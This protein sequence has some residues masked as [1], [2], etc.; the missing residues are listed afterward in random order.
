[1]NAEQ[2][3]DELQSPQ[4][5][6]I[7]V[8][9]TQ[10]ARFTLAIDRLELRQAVKKDTTHYKGCTLP[11]GSLPGMELTFEANDPQGGATVSTQ[12]PTSNWFLR[13]DTKAATNVLSIFIAASKLLPE[14]DRITESEPLSVIREPHVLMRPAAPI[15]LMEKSQSWSSIVS[16]WDTTPLRPAC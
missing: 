7:H 15:H 13:K 1:M 8:T 2:A 11:D 6:A 12:N 4:Q 16:F 5:T 9:A 10:Y 3:C 14:F